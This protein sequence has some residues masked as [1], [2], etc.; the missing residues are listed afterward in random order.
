MYQKKL[1]FLFMDILLEMLISH[2]VEV[3]GLM[4]AL[5]HGVEY[6]DMSKVGLMGLGDET[7]I[8]M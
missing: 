3:F 6:M 2:A 8:V 1:L 7:K 4:E 5:H